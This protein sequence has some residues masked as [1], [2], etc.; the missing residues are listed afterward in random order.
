M[1]VLLINYVLPLFLTAL[2]ETKA[3]AVSVMISESGE[4]SMSAAWGLH[5]GTFLF[6]SIHINNAGFYL[7]ICLNVSKP[8][9]TIL[10]SLKK[11]W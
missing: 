1:I 7:T 11:Y 10:C 4:H 9:I 6:T 8:L 3:Y 2:G 5:W